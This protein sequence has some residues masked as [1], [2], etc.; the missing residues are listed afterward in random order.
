VTAN[1]ELVGHAPRAL[2]TVLISQ[3]RLLIVGNGSLFLTR[4]QIHQSA[5]IRQSSTCSL[6]QCFS[7]YQI[8][9]RIDAWSCDSN[10]LDQMCREQSQVTQPITLH[11]HC[12]TLGDSG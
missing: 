5:T 8:L 2:I 12:L 11:L 1:A 4:V 10:I 9:S 7:C 6:K 3:P